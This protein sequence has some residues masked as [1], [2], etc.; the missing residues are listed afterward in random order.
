MKKCSNIYWQHHVLSN[1]PKKL[2]QL[3]EV[4]VQF[5]FIIST[6]V[7][8]KTKNLVFVWASSRC[9]FYIYLFI[10]SK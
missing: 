4:I 3:E 8:N 1:R 7:D 5:V 6:L 9:Q 2:N 10:Q